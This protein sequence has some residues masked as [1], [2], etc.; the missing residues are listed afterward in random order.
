MVLW[1][2]LRLFVLFV[3]QKLMQNPIKTNGIKWLVLMASFC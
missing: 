1:A 3:W 2:L